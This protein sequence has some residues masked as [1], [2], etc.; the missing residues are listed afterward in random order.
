MHV[1]Y[2][3]TLT[4]M[5]YYLVFTS[6]RTCVFSLL[7]PEL[8][9]CSWGSYFSMSRTKVAVVTLGLGCRQGRS[10]RHLFVI[11][12]S[13]W[14]LCEQRSFHSVVCWGVFY[15]GAR[16]LRPTPRKQKRCILFKVLRCQPS[17]S[18]DHFMLLCVESFH[19]GARAP[20]KTKNSKDKLQYF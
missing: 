8:H 9:S 14:L 5:S 7:P 15:F 10:K 13:I 2:T 16:M 3:I 17:D 6:I 4:S 1:I 11:V 18:Q 20:P 12:H 19:A